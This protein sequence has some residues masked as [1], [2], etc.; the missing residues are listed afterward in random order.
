[1][2][3]VDDQVYIMMESFKQ[4][5]SIFGADNKIC[6]VNL[7]KMWCEYTCNPTQYLFVQFLGYQNVSQGESVV[8][9]TMAKFTVDEDMA[10]TIFTSCQ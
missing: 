9:M 4:L 2:C 7:K 3:C 10:C 5:D 6:G 1:M 8:N